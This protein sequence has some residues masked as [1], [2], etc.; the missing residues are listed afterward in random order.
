M[1]RARLQIEREKQ[2][3]MAELRGQISTLAIAAASKII[4]KNLDK[5]THQDMIQQFI[6]EAGETRWQN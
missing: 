1:E 2:S 3:M 5:A 6:D 4:E